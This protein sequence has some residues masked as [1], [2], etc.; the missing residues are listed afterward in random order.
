M[1]RVDSKAVEGLKYKVSLRETESTGLNLL[2][3][4]G[5]A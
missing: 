1:K 4:K 5:K 3:R 2:L